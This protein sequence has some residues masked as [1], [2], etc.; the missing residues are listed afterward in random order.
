ML[1]LFFFLSFLVAF[2]IG[3]L[4]L[5]SYIKRAYEVGITGFDIHKPNTPAVA[6][7]G[8]IVLMLAYLIG[9]FTFIPLSLIHI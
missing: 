3:L 7:C 5:P 8:G 9:L 1:D 6:E 4:L 2:F